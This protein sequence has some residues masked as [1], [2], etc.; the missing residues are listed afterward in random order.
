[1]DHESI[2]SRIG[3]LV[4]TWCLEIGVPFTTAGSWTLKKKEEERGAEPDE[5]WIFGPESRAKRPDLAVEVLW[6]SGRIDKLDIYRKLGVREVWYWRKGRITPYGL[7]RG[8]Y[9]ALRRSRVLVGI[10]LDHLARSIDR[11]TTSQS[12]LDYRAALRAL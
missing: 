10:D 6:T 8:R 5:C 2:K 4:E 1:L 3:R 11:P 7:Q 9:V 12:V